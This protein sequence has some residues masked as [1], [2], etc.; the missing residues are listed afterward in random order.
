MPQAL[1]V[2][3]PVRNA[4]EHLEAQIERV[5]DILPEL[6]N[7]FDV[8]IV[9]DGS[10]D[11]TAEIA[12]D[13]SLRYPQ[14]AVVSH[15]QCRGMEAA[16]D[17]ALERCDGE[18]VVIHTSAE[19]LDVDVLRQACERSDLAGRAGAA[20]GGMAEYAA[21]RAAMR[22]RGRTQWVDRL[23]GWQAAARATPAATSDR[24]GSTRVIQRG[25]ID[26]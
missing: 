24:G 14:V 17:S 9:D 26:K 19:P 12:H 3:F 2:C 5:L 8:V 15:A 7:R 13:L 20:R 21:A 18:L 22:R 4:Q 11:D 25:R 6:T 16:V 10:T 23:M 1:S